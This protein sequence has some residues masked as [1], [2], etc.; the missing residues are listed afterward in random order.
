MGIKQT[1]TWHT[2]FRNK[3]NTSYNYIQ[4]RFLPC[5]CFSHQYPEFYVPY[6]DALNFVIH[7]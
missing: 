4:G 7:Q 2:C 3:Y 1:C 5:S 6:S